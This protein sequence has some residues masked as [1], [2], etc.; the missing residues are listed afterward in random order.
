MKSFFGEDIKIR[1]GL[2]AT[3]VVLLLG[4]SSVSCSKSSPP[5]VREIIVTAMPTIMGESMANLSTSTSRFVVRGT[6]DI[7]S[8]GLQY[9]LDQGQSWVDIPGGCPPSREYA[10]EILVLTSVEV[11]VRAGTRYAF[12]NAARGQVRLVIPPTGRLLTFVSG[13]SSPLSS[14]T[15][16]RLVAT[17]PSTFTGYPP[18]PED[19]VKMDLHVTGVVYAE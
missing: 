16:P 15:E 13:S 2:V 8:N 4:V 19:T 1:P 14:N 12:T 17:M 18:E 9:S 10:F 3:I 5:Q 7:R 6:C 11:W